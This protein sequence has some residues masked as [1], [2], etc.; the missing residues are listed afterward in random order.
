MAQR[1]A[2]S[3]Q[4][5][6]VEVGPVS[7]LGRGPQGANPGPGSILDG[8]AYTAGNSGA[9][10]AHGREPCRRSSRFTSGWLHPI[11]AVTSD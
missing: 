1:L 9:L 8:A 6:H 3:Q 7:A 4:Q 5:I 2:H 11:W 10:W